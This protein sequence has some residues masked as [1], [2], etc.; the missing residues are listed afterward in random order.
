MLHSSGVRSEARRTRGNAT[1]GSEGEFPATN[2][3]Q[4]LQGRSGESEHLRMVPDSA[5]DWKKNWFRF[6]SSAPT[7]KRC[8]CCIALC[9]LFFLLYHNPPSAQNQIYL[10]MWQGYLFENARLSIIHIFT[11]MF[12][13]NS[14]VASRMRSYSVRPDKLASAWD[15]LAECFAIS[16]PRSK[17]QR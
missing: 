10:V 1:S 16:T 5:A 3:R 14:V 11:S 7:V 13:K 12:Q 8:S 6:L 17:S 4:T 2:W 9:R 15:F